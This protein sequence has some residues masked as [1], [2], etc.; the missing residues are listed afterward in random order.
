VNSSQWVDPEDGNKVKLQREGKRRRTKIFRTNTNGDKYDKRIWR[1]ASVP[2][3]EMLYISES[4]IRTCRTSDMNGITEKAK[5]KKKQIKGNANI[6]KKR[7]LQICHSYRTNIAM[8]VLSDCIPIL[9]DPP[10]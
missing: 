4:T 9:S 6:Y 7:V 2:R 10:N 3:P 8:G 5:G 1:K